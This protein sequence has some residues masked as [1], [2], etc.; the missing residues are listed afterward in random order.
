M[1]IH[2]GPK[3]GSVRAVPVRDEEWLTH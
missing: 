1:G 2:M 3:I